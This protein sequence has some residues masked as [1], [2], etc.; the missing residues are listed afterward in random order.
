MNRRIIVPLNETSRSERAVPVAVEFARRLKASL[1]L[2][3]V[4]DW[5]NIQHPGHPGY[6]ESIMAKYPDLSAESVVIKTRADKSSAI[7]S[8][9]GPADIICIGTDHTSA[10]AEMLLRSIFLDIVR[11]FHGPVIAVGPHA[12]MPPDASRVLL[13]VD[14]HEHAEQGLDLIPQIVKPAGFDPFLVQVLTE[15]H[16]VV[17]GVHEAPETSYLR[18]LAQRDAAFGING[19]DVLHGDPVKAIADYANSPEIAAIAFMTDALD[20]IGRLVSPSLANELI[21]HAN[22]PLILLGATTPVTMSRH[23]IPA[24]P[25]P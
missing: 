3:S 24:N 23:F 9:A 10:V 21:A 6:H 25:N 7:R 13:C 8:L 14:G 2:V 15:K 20:A 17:T 18:S 11:S 22:R 19:W 1:V 12:E 5:P 4:V 16:P